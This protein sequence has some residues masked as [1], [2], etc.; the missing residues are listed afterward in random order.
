MPYGEPEESGDSKYSI[1]LNLN[2]GNGRYDSAMVTWVPDIGGAITAQEK[3]DFF[4]ALVD[5][6]NNFENANVEMN[7]YASKQYSLTSTYQPI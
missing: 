5:H 1:V 6:M 3:L 2:F 7:T 4:A